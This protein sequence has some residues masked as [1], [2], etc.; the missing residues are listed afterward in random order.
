MIT[1]NLIFKGL[2]RYGV[3]E[4]PIILGQSH[5]LGPTTSAFLSLVGW[6]GK[7]R[8]RADAPNPACA[9]ADVECDGILK[10]P[11]KLGVSEG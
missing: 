4:D 3:K 7:L 2:R 1:L 10:S 8:S 11:S 5:P 6:S 9:S